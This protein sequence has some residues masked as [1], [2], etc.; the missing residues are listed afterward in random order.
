MMTFIKRVVFLLPFV[1][2][3]CAAPAHVCA[4]STAGEISREIERIIGQ[5]AAERKQPTT[6]HLASLKWET[7][8]AQRIVELCAA[9]RNITGSDK[10]EGLR[11]SHMTLVA[12]SQALIESE[13]QYIRRHG[14]ESRRP[15]EQFFNWDH[16]ENR[17]AI[18]TNR[19]WSIEAPTEEQRTGYKKLLNTE[20]EVLRLQTQNCMS[21]MRDKY[22]AAWER[23]KAL[24]PLVEF[25][26]DNPPPPGVMQR[27]FIESGVAPPPRKE[28]AAMNVAPVPESAA[29]TQ[30]AHTPTEQELDRI[31]G[32]D[33]S[34]P[35][36]SRTFSENQNAPSAAGN[37]EYSRPPTEDP[38]KGL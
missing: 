38:F 31:L 36:P 23:L 25:S 15:C 21:D 18:E 22:P 10:Y 8:A 6:G 19:K 9:Y 24:V 34:S 14:T 4:Q 32:K 17:S 27:A 28:T 2:A 30:A 37:T 26:E 35:D 29:D 12:T 7:A 33:N 13:E 16:D 20:V 1:V 3:L 11:T 5:M